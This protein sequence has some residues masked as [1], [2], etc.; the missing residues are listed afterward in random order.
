MLRV[1]HSLFAVA[2]AAAL[3]FAAGGALA[4]QSKGGTGKKIVC[5]KDK[6]GKVV[7]CGDTVPPEYQ[8]N[9][10]K[11]LDKR[12]ITRG[13]TETAEERAKKE[14]MDKELSA[15]KADE[16]K[17]VAEQRRQDQALLNAFTNETEIDL[18]RDRDLQVVDGQL[19]QM[20]VSHKNNIERHKEI[21]SRMDATTKTGKPATDAQKEDLA[22]ADS[23][24]AKIEQT[25]AAREKDKEDI[26]K[27]YGEMKDR[28]MKLRGI[29]PTQAAAPAAPAAPAKK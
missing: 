22:R 19:T 13:T 26:R 25:I 12:G 16:K 29:G 27:R 21:K 9:A 23:D 1:N 3:A 20:R 15:Q 14:A 8:D 24:L 18:K 11:E 6:D 7:G 10:T 2:L 28:Y 17:K 5:W 4:Q